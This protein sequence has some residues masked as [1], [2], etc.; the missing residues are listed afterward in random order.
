M[1]ASR[2]MPLFVR[3]LCKGCDTVRTFSEGA[4]DRAASETID[5]FLLVAE[6]EARGFCWRRRDLASREASERFG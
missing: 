2:D 4:G 3:F 5:R 6:I 1:I